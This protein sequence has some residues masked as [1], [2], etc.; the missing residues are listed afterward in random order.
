MLKLDRQ[1]QIWGITGNLG[2]GKSLSAVSIAVNS[3]ASGYFVVSNITLKIDLLSSVYGQHVR[4]LYQHFSFDD[5]LFD[6]FKLPVGSPRGSNGNKRV[7]IIM[8]ECAEWVDQY[9]NARDP[10][11][12]RFWSWIRHSS[13][14]SQDVILIIQRQEF[15]HKVLRSLVSRW[16]IVDDL[17]SW[18]MPILRMRVPFASSFV[19]QH[20]Y[21][22]LGNEISSVQFL[23]K[24]DYG[25][26][27]DTS[28]CLNS[29][30]A[31]YNLEYT[32]NN[33]VDNTPYLLIAFYFFTIL[34]LLYQSIGSQKTF[35]DVFFEAPAPVAG[36]P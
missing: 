28:E 9:A 32:V 8:D 21:D 16:V 35:L 1:P 3:I 19:M 31:T 26:Y 18:R 15:L 4:Q 30:G 33:S 5:P 36:A 12:G 7:V 13:K 25:C 17:A 27:Y 6:P 22:R 14:R 23:N 24:I 2:G 20:I 29:D 34:Y 10:K 11:I